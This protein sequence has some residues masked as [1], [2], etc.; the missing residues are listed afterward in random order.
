MRPYLLIAIDSE[1][2]LSSTTDYDTPQ[3]AL[4]DAFDLVEVG[5]I[6]AWCFGK[7][8]FAYRNPDGI[9]EALFYPMAQSPNW[10]AEQ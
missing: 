1:D 8:D 3:Q 9:I 7:M 4:T 5:A 6:S 2:G 10:H